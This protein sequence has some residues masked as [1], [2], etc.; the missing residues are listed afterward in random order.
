M[1]TRF[2]ITFIATVEYDVCD[3]Y[4]PDCSSV[5]EMLKIDLK[6][7]ND[8]PLLMLDYGGVKW[9]ITGEILNKRMNDHVEN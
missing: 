8:D 3:E 9:N 6:N 4:Y 1:S 2:K 5:E 7:A